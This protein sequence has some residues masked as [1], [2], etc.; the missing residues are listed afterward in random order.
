LLLSRETPGDLREPVEI[1]PA[2]AYLGRAGRPLLAHNKRAWM[3]EIDGG[4]VALVNRSPH[5]GCRV[6]WKSDHDRFI[7]PCHGQ[8]HR[9]DGSYEK[10]PTARDM[11]RYPIVALDAER[12]VVAQTNAAGDPIQVPPESLLYLD[13]AEASELEPASSTSAGATDSP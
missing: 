3:V 10:G 2:S 6:S 1:G 5:A 11:R 8:I 12:Q 9:L 7:D 13:L 4:L